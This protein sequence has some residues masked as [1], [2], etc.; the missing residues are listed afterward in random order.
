[1]RAREYHIRFERVREERNCRR[2]YH[3]LPRAQ[4]RGRKRTRTRC[5]R[6]AGNSCKGGKTNKL[7]R[8]AA[9]AGAVSTSWGS[10]VRAQYRPLERCAVWRVHKS[11]AGRG[12]V[13]P[14]LG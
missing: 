3:V 11:L 10:L 6:R 5:A 9:K 13:I 2:C 12:C 1:M 14:A 8:M 4:K 7:A